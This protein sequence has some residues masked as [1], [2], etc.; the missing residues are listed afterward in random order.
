MGAGAELHDTAGFM[1][2]GYHATASA[3]RDRYFWPKMDTDVKKYIKVCP[4]CQNSKI[5][6]QKPRGLLINL[7][8]PV[9]PGLAYNMDFVTDLPSS[10]YKGLRYDMALVIV[11][12]CSYRTYILP[13]R[14]T[15][16]AESISEAFFDEVVCKSGN[17]VP[18]YIVSDRDTRFNNEFWQCLHRKFG[19]QIRMSSARSQ[20]TNGLAER[21]I[22]VIEEVLRSCVNYK[23][24][25]WTQ[26]IGGVLLT[27]NSAPRLKLLN[28]SSLYYERG[29][30]PLLPIDTVETL[31]TAGIRD[32]DMAPVEVLERIKF[33]HDMHSMVREAVREAELKISH[34]AN[35]KRQHVEIF[36]VGTLVRLSLDGVNLN[37]FKFRPC[38]KLNPVWYGPFRVTGLPS[39]ISCA[40]DLQDD[41]YVH[42]VF[43]MSKLKLPSD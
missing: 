28:K 38:K 13:C 11:D 9:S 40:L 41:S 3:V 35:Q 24:D 10:L 17:G 22:A 19:T 20:Q 29:C 43:P 30:Q 23:Q 8:T 33:L 21:T 32:K 26:L 39:P 12:R 1:H 7:D 16:S 36:E 42:N 25:N 14:K 2:R 37:Q 15:D 18:L 27:M 31:Q 34:Y 6:R 5:D 4:E